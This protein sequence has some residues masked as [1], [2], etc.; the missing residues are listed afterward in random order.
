MPCFNAAAHL[1]ASVAS[2][3]GQSFAYIELIVVDDGSTDGSAAIL[4]GIQDPRLRVHSQPNRGVC[5]ARNAGISMAR[6]EYIAFLDADDTWHPDCLRELHAALAA[7]P[8]ALAYCGW[9]NIGLAGP[10]GEPYLP[11]DYED[12]HKLL[13]LF[14][15]CRWPI[16]ACLTRREAIA[17]AGGFDRRFKTSE[18]YLLWLKIGK[19]HPIV[20]VPQVLAYYH[21]HDA[22]QAT[23]NKALVA[24]NHFLAQRAFLAEHPADAHRIPAAARRASME[25]RLVQR[26]LE[27]HWNRDLDHARPIFRTLLRVGHAEPRHWKYVLPALLPRPVH[28]FLM[29]RLD[30][31]APS[32]G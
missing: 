4:A 8:A 10:R 13:T 27:C 29:R 24:I 19:D 20:R 28:A 2:A 22:G 17:A 14:D 3:L 6:G 25:G 31:A 9:Q 16:H 32:S 30:G 5:E 7:S 12:G 11:P 18:D 15:N 23:G 26:G 1:Q 21:F